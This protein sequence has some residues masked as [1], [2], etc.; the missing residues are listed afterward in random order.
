[1][2]ASSESVGRRPRTRYT[3]T[4]D[5]RRALRAW[6]DR[7]AEPTRIESE[8]LLKVFFAEQGAAESVRTTIASVRQWA[9]EQAEENV[10]VARS[11][12]DGDGPFPDRAAV[13]ALTGRF[14]TD[15][16]DMVAR[17]ADWA[18]TVVDDWPDDPK[19]A[20]PEWTVFEEIVRRGER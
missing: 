19:H 2:R 20:Q 3:I 6:L 9:R 18:A 4:A 8:Q 14:M 12:L 17:W 15:F 10:A 1:V 13:L 7:P 5:G 16:V 11:Y